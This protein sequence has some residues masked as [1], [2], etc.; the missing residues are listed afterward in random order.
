MLKRKEFILGA[1]VGLSFAA[2]ATAGGV[3]TWPGAH[4]APVAAQAGRLVPSAGAAGLA[5]AP[6]QGAPLSFADIFQQVAPAVVQID[7]KTRVQRPTGTIQIPGFGAVP[8]PGAPRGGSGEGED[9]N[10]TTALGAG[11]GFLISADGFIVTNNHVVENAEEIKVKLS[12]GRELTARLIG[13]DPLTDLAVIKVEGSTFPFV[14]FE[15][16]AEPRVG[17]WV[18]AVGNPFG[19]G[20]TATAGIVSAKARDIGGNENPYTDFIQIDAAIN[21]GNSGG[22]TFDIYGRVIGVNTAIFSPTGGSVG[23]GFAIPAGIAKETTDRLMRGEK[24]ERGYLGVTIGNLTNEYRESLGLPEGTKGAYITDVTAGA[25]G[26]QGG[27]QAGDVVVSLNGRAIE[28][29]NELTRAVGAVKPGETLRLELLREG[30]RQTI[31]LRAG[32]R[33]ANLGAAEAEAG[34]EATPDAPAAVAG[35]KVEGLTVAPITAALRSR[36]DLADSVRGVVVTAVEARSEAGRLRFQPG[37][38]IVQANGR[39]VTTVRELRDAVEAARTARRPGVL[40]LV[41]T[42]GGNAPIVLPFAKSE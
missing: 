30:R 23:I 15:D 19:L 17:D 13:R 24:I 16:K 31:T 27:L 2:V 35:E 25:P 32:T 8:I 5:F 3:I 9:D 33:P 40:L 18:I 37:M 14:S 4:A 26:D 34:D 28:G 42:S 7:V 6:P 38:V 22:P 21:R 41:R 12:D 10:S 20:G 39:N 1:A 11:S 36:Y 29:S